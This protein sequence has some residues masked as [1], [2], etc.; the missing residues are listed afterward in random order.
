MG[1]FK[2]MKFKWHNLFNISFPNFIVTQIGG[3]QPIDATN[4]EEVYREKLIVN[5]IKSSYNQLL[6]MKTLHLYVGFDKEYC[7]VFQCEDIHSQDI[8]HDKTYILWSKKNEISMVQED[9]LDIWHLKNEYTKLKNHHLE[10]VDY[11][12]DIERFIELS[13][14]H[15]INI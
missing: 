7:V 12:Q 14:K 6:K 5:A 4:D 1:G 9:W 2:R 3:K 11:S 13:L 15:K 8:T 10:K